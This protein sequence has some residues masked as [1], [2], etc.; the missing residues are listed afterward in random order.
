MCTSCQLFDG[1][2]AKPVELEEGPRFRF[3]VGGEVWFR[4]LAVCKSCQKLA[5]TTTPPSNE[6]AS[7]MRHAE[8]CTDIKSLPPLSSPQKHFTR[9]SKSFPRQRCILPQ[10]SE[11][12]LRL[13]WLGCLGM[14]VTSGFWRVDSRPA[15]RSLRTA[16]AQVWR[17]TICKPRPNLA[18]ISEVAPDT[19]PSKLRVQ[20]QS[21]SLRGAC[22]AV[23]PSA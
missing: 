1:H 2:D 21:T 14:D 17:R 16:G 20:M 4:L 5:C 12:S 23:A 7:P 18:S 9:L 6:P 13:L 19:I 10:E 22:P 8:R 15:I 3:L 11:C